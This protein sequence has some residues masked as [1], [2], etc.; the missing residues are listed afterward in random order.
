MG[1]CGR[2]NS[3]SKRSLIW[4]ASTT[5]IKSKVSYTPI[6][7]D[8]GTSGMIV[9]LWMWFNSGICRLSEDMEMEEMWK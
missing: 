6:G 7:T 3:I 8:N 9:F 5:R 1:S 2:K 4:C